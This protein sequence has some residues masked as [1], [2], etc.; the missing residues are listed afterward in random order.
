M[1]FGLVFLQKKNRFRQ[2]TRK[3]YVHSHIKRMIWKLLNYVLLDEIGER[4]QNEASNDVSV[5]DIDGRVHPVVEG[6][7]CD[8]IHESVA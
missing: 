4:E 7:F 1:S 8:D 5:S 2:K 3:D 6:G